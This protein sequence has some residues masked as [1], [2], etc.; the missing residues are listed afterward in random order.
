MSFTL[1]VGVGSPVG[2]ALHLG[3]VGQD[4]ILRGGW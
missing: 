3:S 1:V 4:E 2:Y